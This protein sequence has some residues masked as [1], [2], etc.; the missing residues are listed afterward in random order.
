M[1]SSDENGNGD[2]ISSSN[3]PRFFGP[4]N[5]I[6]GDYGQ[7]LISAAPE[8]RDA[9]LMELTAKWSEVYVKDAYECVQ[10]HDDCL[11]FHGRLDNLG[12][13]VWHDLGA[14]LTE[15]DKDTANRAIAAMIHLWRGRVWLKLIPATSVG[16]TESES[17]T[18]GIAPP[19]GVAFPCRASWLKS[20]CLSED[21]ARRT[22]PSMEDPI[23]RQ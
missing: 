12:V 8:N 2:R 5:A 1:N 3:S 4:L 21:S 13:W 17:R 16:P 10:T 6:I 19:Q 18:T 23:G 15:S 9:V 22:R 20:G 14:I 11:K 7:R